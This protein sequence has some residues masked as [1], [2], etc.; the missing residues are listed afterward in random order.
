MGKQIT[1]SIIVKGEVRELYDAWLDFGNH[2]NF[3]EHITSVTAKGPDVNSWVME[4]PLNT[5]LEWTTKTTREE[6]N[7]RIAWKTIEG[8]LKSSG[9]VTFTPLTQGRVEIT[10]TS[11]MNP[12][13]NLIEKVAIVLFE[14]EEA[15]LEK[16]LRSFK[17]MAEN[18]VEST[19]RI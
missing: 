13:D 5:R 14:D 8:D 9:Q 18:R 12:P 11:L 17:A 10:V 15:Q 2:P 6:E 1:K 3:M 7:Q 16:D 19:G 4:G